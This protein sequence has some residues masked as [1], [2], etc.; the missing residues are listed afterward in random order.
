MKNTKALFNYNL[1]CIA[2]YYLFSVAEKHGRSKQ[3]NKL[4]S[5]YTPTE[6]KPMRVQHAEQQYYNSFK[7]IICKKQTKHVHLT[8]QT[9]KLKSSRQNVFIAIQPI[10][11]TTKKKMTSKFTKQRQTTYKDRRPS[12]RQTEKS[13]GLASIPRFIE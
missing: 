6:R 7:W 11:K 5:N 2:K 12:K 3:I 4:N 13:V 8:K 1:Q 10:S 9:A